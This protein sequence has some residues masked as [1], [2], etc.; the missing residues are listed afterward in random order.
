[1]A[2]PNFFKSYF[3]GRSG[4]KDF[5]EADLPENRL[6]LFRDV[7]HVRAGS[8]VGV[9]LLYLLCWIP[10]V[11]WSFLNLVQLYGLT[12]S[13]AEG[14]IRSVQ[15][16]LFSWLL[17]LAPLIF[18]TGPF[19]MAV[20]RIMRNW[21]RD[22]HSFV[23]TG[24]GAA[25]KENWKQG[26]AYGAISGLLP[27]VAY[28]CIDFYAGMAQSSAL[29]YLPMGIVLLAALAWYLASPIL[30]TMLVTYR[31]GFF[32]QL[33]NAVLM[34]LAALPKAIL[35]RLTTLLVPILLGIVLYIFPSALGWASAAAVVLYAVFMPAFNKL[36][37]ASWANALCE[38]YLNPKI[39]GAGVNIGLR[40]KEEKNEAEQV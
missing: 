24:F 40:P 25:L 37:W 13:A 18:I 38:T 11:I 35:I 23:L 1:M 3:Y 27:L 31:Q 15:N 9:N 32:I 29:F 22:E 21:A 10:A 39:E 7:L 5:T 2:F 14:F 17:V 12:L 30:P 34:T 28:L 16:I 4:K 6:Q 20:S 36:V 33:K 19:T 8:M 26:L